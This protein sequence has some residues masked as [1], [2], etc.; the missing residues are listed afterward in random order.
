MD[1][2]Q[3]DDGYSDDDL[4][5]L[6]ADAFHELQE[7]AI[8]STQQ[9]KTTRNAFPPAITRIS[10]KSTGNVIGGFGRLPF[11]G[12]RSQQGHAPVHSEPPSSD[13]GDFDH[14]M[15]DGEIYDAAE[16]SAFPISSNNLALASRVGDSTQREG[17]R[18]LR[19]GAP[20]QHRGYEGQHQSH[21]ISDVE[22]Q[23]RTI[24]QNINYNSHQ[25]HGMLVSQAGEDAESLRAQIQEVCQH[26]SFQHI[27]R[28]TISKAL[29]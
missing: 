4:D 26:S 25:S 23:N 7:N 2:V 13:Y 29:S 9:P 24:V 22:T 1:E 3:E 6:P 8:R 19:Y 17:W 11:A 21:K 14:E 5:A 18:Q 27:K 15:L 12:I 20:A 28:L 10:T 16:D